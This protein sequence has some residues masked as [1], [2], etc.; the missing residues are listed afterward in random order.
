MLAL[1]EV[2]DE[3]RMQ[4]DCERQARRPACTIGTRIRLIGLRGRAW[5]G[6]GI[7]WGVLGACL[8]GPRGPLTG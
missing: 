7:A 8:G 4:W 5:A 6:L 2:E 3:E 1:A